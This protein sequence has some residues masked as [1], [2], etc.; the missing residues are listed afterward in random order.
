[1][2][3]NNTFGK[4]L[5]QWQIPEH[6]HYAKSVWWYVVFIV[7][8]LGLFTYAL[9][10]SN[11]LFA[12]IIIILTAIITI[13]EKRHPNL[14][15]FYIAEDGII[16]EEKFIPYKNIERFWI[17]YEPPYVKNLYFHID[18]KIKPEL[19]IPLIKM[20][21]VYIRKALLKYIKEDLQEKYISPSDQL[22][23]IMKI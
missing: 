22:G 4:I 17:I 3:N 10:V 7:G 15:N 8:G 13:H 11:F 23:R 2:E 19:S 21:P 6:E 5:A 18:S 1:M 16:L 14:L 20:N 9:W 12:V